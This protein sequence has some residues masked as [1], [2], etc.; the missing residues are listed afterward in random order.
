MEA[1]WLV[2]GGHFPRLDVLL[3]SFGLGVCFVNLHGGSAV[4]YE[5]LL[6]LID[7]TGGLSIPSSSYQQIC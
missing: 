4:N 1:G 3:C 2:D 7:G 5:R 6:R